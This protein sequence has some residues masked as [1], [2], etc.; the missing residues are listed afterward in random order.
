MYDQFAEIYDLQHRAFLDDVPFYLRIA[1]EICHAQRVL[2][3]GCGS[4]RLMVPL[5]EA[6]LD[7]TGVDSSA[8]ML[9]IAAAHLSRVP[10]WAAQAHTLIQADARAP[11]P[12]SPA[13]FDLVVIALN[14]FLH[15]LSCED[16]LAVLRT[17]RTALPPGGHLVID[18]PPNDEMAYQPDDGQFQLE[19]TFIDPA[20]GQEVR[21]YVASR[22]FWATQEQ[23][24]SYRVERWQEGRLRD[25]QMFAFRLRHV[26]RYEMEL[27]LRQSGFALVTWFGD[28]D[29]S[30][31]GEGS[32][33]M[34]AL[35]RAV[36]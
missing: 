28:Y 25:E 2:E 26:F 16:Q 23:E 14:T 22:I 31:Y 24:L 12:L 19:A 7:V 5:I 34:I 15:N 6:G 1:R 36:P 9:R 30:P 3:I 20:S 4:G 35:A 17:A 27:L 11:L 18:I 10:G 29:L 21:K 8:E 33:R 32:L 13:S